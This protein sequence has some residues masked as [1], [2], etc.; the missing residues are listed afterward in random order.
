MSGLPYLDAARIAALIS[1]ADAV[2][3]IEDALRAI[4]PAADAARSIVDVSSGQL[5]LMPAEAG[6]SVGVKI[7]A[8]APGNATRELP[9]V[10]GVYVLFDAETLT[11][12]AILDGAALTTLRTPAVSVAAIRPSLIE[13]A[14]PPRVVVFGAG[15]QGVGHVDT[16]IALF[17]LADVS[18][19][20]RH[21]GERDRTFAAGSHE[22]D[23]V[24]RAADVVVCAT[25]AREPLFDSSLLG[26]DTIVVAVGSHEP[27]AR[28]LDRALMAR[29][30][31][32]VEDVATA[33]RECGDVIQA[34]DDQSLRADSLVT[35]RDIVTG[36]VAPATD[37]PVVF[38]GSGMAWQDLAVASRIYDRL[39]GSVE[40]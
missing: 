18:Y 39:A 36:A 15:P 14:D 35:I 40:K 38:K 26:D 23:A 34:I 16:L 13:R 31:V 32:I 3:A 11:P 25:T 19:I 21:P 12:Q 28:E 9:R 29:A 2:A 17:E 33:L 5:V 30:Q 7:I 8:V 10:Q 20:V 6:G 1:P 22:A 24:F 27:D 37:R 4:D